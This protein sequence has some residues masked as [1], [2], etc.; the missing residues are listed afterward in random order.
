ME[1]QKEVS[2][3]RQENESLL[4]VPSERSYNDTLIT[5]KKN[6]VIFG[7]SITKGINTLLLNKKLINSKVGCKFFCDATSK[8]FVH[9]MKPTLQENEFDTSILDMGA[10]DVLK[11]GSNVDTV[12][13]NI[14]NTENHCNNFGVK[15]IIIF[16]S[17]L[18]TRLNVILLTTL[19]IQCQKHGYSFIDNSNVSSVNL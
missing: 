11:L 9:Y 5:Q 7:D 4:T 6:V 14:I 10:N 12:S 1:N 13:K 16:G 3:T 2:N 17:T 19:T 8:G 15:Q 18:A